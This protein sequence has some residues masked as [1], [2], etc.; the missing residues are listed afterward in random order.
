MS[1][2]AIQQ[3]L[4]K[5]LQWDHAVRTGDVTSMTALAK[6]EDLSQR[7]IARVMNLAFLAP[8]IME[9]II[10]GDVPQALSLDRLKQGFPLAWEKQRKTLGFS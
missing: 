1:V 3:A 7:Y 2:Q 10:R 9:A 8:D 6:R 5:A 4:A